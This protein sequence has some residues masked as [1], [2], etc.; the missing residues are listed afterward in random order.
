LRPGNQLLKLIAYAVAV[1]IREAVAVAVIA[2][3][4]IRARAVFVGSV[5]IVV[6]SRCVLATRYFELI[7]YTV[8]VCIREAV[9][10]AVITRICIRARAVVVRRICIKV[11]RRSID[12][13]LNSILT[14]TVVVFGRLIIVRSFGHPYNRKH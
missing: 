9:A 5:T 4:S 3:I 2:R 7:A 8:A 13:T 1:C 12:A 14:A 6:A 10:V 11:A